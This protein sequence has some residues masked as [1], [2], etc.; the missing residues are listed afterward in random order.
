MDLD[1]YDIGRR[2]DLGAHDFTAEAI[3]AFA[4]KYDPQTFHIDAEA[5]KYSIYGGLCASGWHTAAVCMRK[6]VDYWSVWHAELRQLGKPV[7]EFGPSPGFRNLRWPKPVYAGDTIRFD[8]TY[9]Q[10]R[11]RRSNPHWGIV[12]AL[13][14]GHNQKGDKVLS[15]ESTVLVRI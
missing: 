13:T 4:E 15:V 8:L 14:E 1:V 10:V 12:E 3:I 6:K 2:R 9:T 7:P 5:A 11:E